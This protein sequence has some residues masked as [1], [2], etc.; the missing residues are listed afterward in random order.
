MSTATELLRKRQ[1]NDADQTVYDLEKVEQEE[2]KEPDQVP[3]LLEDTPLY[4]C[5]KLMQKIWSMKY[6]DGL[7]ATWTDI[8][9]PR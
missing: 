1:Q 6:E 5:S 3:P 7:I 4:T 2:L 8:K 9:Y